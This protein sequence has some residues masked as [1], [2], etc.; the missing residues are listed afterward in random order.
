MSVKLLTR[1][2]VDMSY[3]KGRY[4][5]VQPFVLFSYV[6]ELYKLHIVNYTCEQY[7]YLVMERLR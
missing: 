7:L 5:E 6:T 2:V 1:I 4:H 3:E